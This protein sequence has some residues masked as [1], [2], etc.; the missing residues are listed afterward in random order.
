[1]KIMH[2]TV[3]A[4][5]ALG[6]LSACG[7]KDRPLMN[8]Q[9]SSDGPDEFA[10]LPGKP[11]QSPDFAAPLPAPTPGGSNLTD[12]TPKADA[13]AALGGKPGRLALSGPGHIGRGDGGLVSYASRFGASGNIRRV[14]ATEDRVFRSKNRGKL[15]E[16][17]FNNTV[18]FSAYEP[19]SL[20]Q[21]RELARF[22]RLGVK[23]P[24]APPDPEVYGKP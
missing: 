6:V 19:M 18:Y 3:V 20:D 8:I 24:S 5:I 4:L 10:I 7:G 2:S 21:H 14:L 11:L 9:A 16:R 22:R 23:T 15:L 13:V 17:W 12:P 1:M